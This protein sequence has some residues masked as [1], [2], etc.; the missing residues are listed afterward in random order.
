MPYLYGKSME[1]L[2]A[3]Q[4]KVKSA[5]YRK[6]SD[7]K[8]QAWTTP[9]PVTY[10]ERFS[11][12]K[13][14]LRVGESWGN[15]WDCAW[16]NFTGKVPPEACGKKVVLIIDISG[17]A[18][19]VDREGNPVQGLTN[20]T[21]DFDY[22]LGRPGKTVYEI[23]DCAAGGEEIDLW[24][25]TG[26]N[27]L[28]GKY[29]DSGTIVEAHIAV[30][31]EEMRQLY[32]DMEVLND[33]LSC[34]P[35]DS[36][37]YG[38]ILVSLNEAS[39][40]LSEYTSKEAAAARNI[41]K[42]EL[43]RKCGDEALSISAVGHAHIDLAWLWPIRETIR[44]GAR[45]FSTALK[46][47]EKYPDYVFG[48]SQP[49]LYQWVKDHYPILYKEVKKQIEAGRWEAQG[50]MWVEADTNVSGGEALVRQVLL[51]KRFFREEFGKDMK[52][53]WLPDVFGYTASL[54]QIL[55][56]SG[57]DYFM[58]IKLSWSKFNSHPHH[59]FW[60]QGI[61]GSKVLSHMPPEGTYNSSA[62]PSAIVKAEKE[63][64][65][66][67]ISGDCLMLFGIGDGGG[68]PGE[69]HLER[70]TREK[71]LNGLVPVVQEPAANFF[72]KIAVD[73]DKYKTWFGELY[74]EFHQ[75][76]YTS[77]ARN[78]RFNRKLELALREAE[79]AL[80]QAYIQKG[81]AYPQAEL[82]AIWKEILLYQFHD[83]LPGSSI[84]RVYEESLERYSHLLQ[85]VN[86]LA[87]GA[88][89][90]LLEAP[91]AAETDD[92]A[93]ATRGRAS[94]MP[95]DS[96]TGCLAAFNSLSWDRAEW[97]K[98]GDTWYYAEIPAMS[99]KV[100]GPAENCS[101]SLLSDDNVL[102]NDR[103]KI[104][105]AGDGSIA[106]IFDKENRREVIAPGSR[107]NR[108]SVYDDPGDAWDFPVNYDQK[109]SEHFVLRKAEVLYDGPEAVR[110]CE[111]VYGNSV[112][113]QET[114]LVQGSRRIDFRTSV[115]WQETGKMLRAA[116]PV[117]VFAAEATFDIQFGNVKRP[118]HRNTSW[119]LAKYEVC[120]HKWVDLSQ[121]DYGVALLNDCKYG[122]K[123]IDNLIDINLLR[124]P[125]FPDPAADRA[126]HEFTYSLYPHRGD[127]A[128]GGVA[129]AA[130]GLNIP[131]SSFAVSENVPVSGLSTQLLSLEAGN[132]VVESV[133]KAEDNGD[134][135]VRIYENRGAGTTGKLKIGFEYKSVSLVNMLEEA[136]DPA[137]LAQATLELYFKPF[138]IHTLRI[139]I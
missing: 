13:R 14:T 39:N 58:T 91:G 37:G 110:R 30:C 124:S 12:G 55:K 77:Q 68:G 92:P 2:K 90:S 102:E 43:D 93:P 64:K 15:L 46:N 84:T 136:C 27:D 78:K 106:S 137:P 23:T 18:C 103:I 40:R 129:Q 104:I 5:V 80:V 127:P 134:I 133:K 113:T 97:I 17:E 36:A 105:F 60:W 70:L 95:Q 115:D 100:I 130:Y 121:S 131:I 71:R 117:D 7:L 86:E 41:L 108:L 54:P 139:R 120:A 135:I 81:K 119:D 11:G 50:A 125:S 25:D 112:L 114:V 48:A 122:Y 89:L 32:Y 73:S 31:D 138:E 22:S 38:S 126:V 51:G 47:I 10:A 109:P 53:L 65:D 61:D 26:C 116:F 118:T 62:G 87:A 9:E 28:F 99:G 35:E 21:S 45:T 79:Y 44:K 98:H 52:T 16:F 69:E 85:R 20:T 29:K 132:L 63:F 49:Q 74:L 24:A 6:I 128:E 33:M 83:I 8:I 101:G 111:Y 88:Y 19:V 76:T 3:V 82:E 59:T 94:G 123:V 1:Y 75:G 34:L 67:G 56:K 42:K 96:G 107:A 66:K 57:V 4:Q 72:N